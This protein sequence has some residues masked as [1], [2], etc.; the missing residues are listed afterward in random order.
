MQSSQRT[1]SSPLALILTG[2]A[3]RDEL[4]NTHNEDEDFNEEDVNA[5]GGTDKTNY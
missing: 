5:R 1:P 2:R 3:A 4:I